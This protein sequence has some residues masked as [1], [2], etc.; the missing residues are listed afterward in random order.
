MIAFA[1]LE[2]VLAYASLL[3]YYIDPSI[4]KNGLVFAAGRLAAAVSAVLSGYAKPVLV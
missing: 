4:G 3:F 2:L 1:V